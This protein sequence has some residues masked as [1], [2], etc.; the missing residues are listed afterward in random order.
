MIRMM[1]A[2]IVGAIAVGTATAAAPDPFAGAWW[3]TDAFDGSDL[4]LQISMD[5]NGVRRVVLTDNRTGPF[6]GGGP[7][8]VI[9]KGAVA[10][11]T[12]E[13]LGTIRCPNFAGPATLTIVA[14][15]GNLVVNDMEV[16]SRQGKG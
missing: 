11:S 9:G 2:L 7:A 6:C 8:Q 10:G 13:V 5:A 15:G 4:R 3:A 12:M 14:T 16:F 1:C